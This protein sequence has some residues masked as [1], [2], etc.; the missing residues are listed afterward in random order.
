MV[1][2]AFSITTTAWRARL[3][4]RPD[5]DRLIFVI[6]SEFRRACAAEQRYWELSGKG[7][8]ESA[9]DSRAAISRQV[10]EEFY[11]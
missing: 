8:G 3:Q 5:R 9:Q 1:G 11:S 4:S 2:R 10:F 7:A 6:L